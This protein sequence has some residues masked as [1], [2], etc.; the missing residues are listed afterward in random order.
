MANNDA[1]TLEDS[2]RFD[3][4]NSLALR[5]WSKSTRAKKVD[6]EVIRNEIW[7]VLQSNNFDFRSLLALDNLQ[8]LEKYIPLKLFAGWHLSTSDTY[9]PGSMMSQQIITSS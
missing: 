6:P 7:D 9:G 1:S 5:H 3:D 2:E 8:L 4:W